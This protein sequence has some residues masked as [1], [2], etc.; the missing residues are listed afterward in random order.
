[1]IVVHKDPNRRP[2]G[3]TVDGDRAQPH[4]FELRDEGLRENG[5]STVLAR[6]VDLQARKSA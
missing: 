3:T 4:F 1:L 6:L 2:N 5:L